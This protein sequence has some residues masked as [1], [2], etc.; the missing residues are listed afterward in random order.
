EL[1]DAQVDHCP[2]AGLLLA[3]EAGPGGDAATAVPDG[4]REVDLPEVAALN[5][6]LHRVNVRVHA[7]IEVNGEDLAGLLGGV[8]H[9]LRLGGA[10]GHGLLDQHVQPR[11]EGG[12]GHG[13]MKGVGRADADGVDRAA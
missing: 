13:R 8:D 2:A 5:V 9:P 10:H 4:A 11:L 6:P 12:D 1:V 7:V 3:D